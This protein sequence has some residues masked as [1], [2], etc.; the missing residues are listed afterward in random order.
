[1]VQAGVCT[2]AHKHSWPHCTSCTCLSRDVWARSVAGALWGCVRPCVLEVEPL[3][4]PP[5]LQKL[6]KLPWARARDMTVTLFWICLF[7]S[8]MGP[9]HTIVWVI[10]LFFFIFKFCILKRGGRFGS[11]A[12]SLHVMPCALPF[13]QLHN[14]VTPVPCSYSECCFHVFIYFVTLMVANRVAAA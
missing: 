14:W 13:P 1:M 4:E 12:N 7:D 8:M 9:D 10:I 3:Q 6:L 5:S 11:V 2:A